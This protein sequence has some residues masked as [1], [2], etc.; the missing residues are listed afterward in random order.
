MEIYLDANAT[1]PVLPEA[2]AA[3][4]A[5]MEQD[6][7]NPSSTHSTGLRARA[8]VDAARDKARAV[9]GVPTGHVL[10]MSGATEAIQTAVLSAL[11]AIRDRHAVGEEAGLLLYGATEHKAVPESL[12][13]WN[14]VLGLQLQ[15]LAIPVDANGQH[16]LA[17]LSV[18]AP[19]AALVCTMA[20]NNETGVVSD[21]D[22]IEAILQDSA[23]LWLVDS[24]QALGKLDLQ[25]A[26]RRIDYA[27]FSGHKLY[28]PKGIGLL[29]VRE[30]APLT[31]LMTGGGQESSVRAGTE[32]MA[33]IAALGAVLGLLQEGRHFQD[34]ATLVGFRDRL[35]AALLDAFPG[36]VFNARPEQSL[37]TTLNFSVPGL[38]SSVLMNLFDAAG[39][40]VSSGS[41]CSAAKAQPSYVLEAMGL[42]AWQTASA[43]RMSFGP[44]DSAE[45]IDEA[46]A[47]IRACGQALRAH[48]ASQSASLGSPMLAAPNELSAP[49][50]RAMLAAH[51][52]T[53]LVDVR[54]AYEQSL[55]GPA[56]LCQHVGYQAL[57]LSRVLEALPAWAA[58][59]EQ[60]FVFFCRS[61][62]RSAQAASALQQAGHS[63]CWSLSGGLALWPQETPALQ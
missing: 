11:V 36:L 44:A 19:R 26:K 56:E 21:L 50:L 3:A 24:V 25:L 43:I 4:L 9:L 42:P 30:G 23:A 8:L 20:A 12:K 13:H 41:A 54:E 18:H 35:G 40:R 47:R 57:P 39:V 6:F 14:A 2:R 7:G 31:P 58:K 22:G 59:P 53:C 60:R 48:G 52:D 61:G 45:F 33:G 5:A 51:P 34:H 17:W 63:Q 27:S 29:Y 49:Q 16:D 38:S 46:C 15:V 10:F 55:G 1:T 28:A 37:P 62:G 32:N